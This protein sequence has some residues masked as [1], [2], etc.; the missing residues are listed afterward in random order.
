MFKEIR[1]ILIF[2]A[3]LA[4][5]LIAPYIF[6]GNFSKPYYAFAITLSLIVSVLFI[7]AFSE[8]YKNRFAFFLFLI[9]VFFYLF[10]LP[11]SYMAWQAASIVLFVIQILFSLS[12]LAVILID[13]SQD[14]FDRDFMFLEKASEFIYLQMNLFYKFVSGEKYAEK[15]QTKNN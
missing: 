6:V 7:L 9:A 2:S 10:T 15:L 12:V 5:I 11:Y 1:F 3:V 8:E 14:I 13:F 4:S